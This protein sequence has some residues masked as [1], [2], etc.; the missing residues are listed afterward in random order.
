MVAN[1][2]PETA[3]KIFRIDQIS[4]MLSPFTSANIKLGDWSCVAVSGTFEVQS[5]DPSG[6]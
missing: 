5:K 4:G 6:W 3:L 2:T 1:S